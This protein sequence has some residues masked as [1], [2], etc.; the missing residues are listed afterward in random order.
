MLILLFPYPDVDGPSNIT[1]VAIVELNVYKHRVICKWKSHS[2]SQF[3]IHRVVDLVRV[4]GFY[5]SLY[6]YQLFSC[7]MITSHYQL[8]DTNIY[9]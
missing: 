9:L 6:F 4:M 2:T 7:H 8:I 5:F 3:L 1:H